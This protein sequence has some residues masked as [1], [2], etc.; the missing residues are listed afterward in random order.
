M[1]SSKRV[2]PSTD[3]YFFQDPLMSECLSSPYRTSRYIAAIGE[4]GILGFIEHLYSR[5]VLDTIT[6]SPARWITSRRSLPE[7]TL[8]LLHSTAPQPSKIDRSENG[9]PQDV[10]IWNYSTDPPVG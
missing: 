9:S 6:R 8:V 1:L 10:E 5:A 3:L 4:S 2:G 7:T